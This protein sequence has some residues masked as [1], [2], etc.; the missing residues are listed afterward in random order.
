MKA[1]IRGSPLDS[2]IVS[3]LGG[4]IILYVGVYG[5]YILLTV[6]SYS[7]YDLLEEIFGSIWG[8]LIVVF[9]ILLFFDRNRHGKYGAAIIILSFASWYGTSGGLFVGFILA[10]L[11][12]IMGLTWKPAKQKINDPEDSSSRT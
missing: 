12:G 10:F 7:V 9:S 5:L 2:S 3:I 4:I 8:L 1:Y 11:G 6:G